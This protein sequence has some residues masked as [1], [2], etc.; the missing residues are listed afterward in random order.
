MNGVRGRIGKS[1]YLVIALDMRAKN[2]NLNF[3]LENVST[4]KVV[5][6]A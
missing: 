5:K 6:E 4:K 3:Y 1:L 2:L